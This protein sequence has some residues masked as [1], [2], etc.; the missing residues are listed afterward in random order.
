MRRELVPNIDFYAAMNPDPSDVDDASPI[1]VYLMLRTL[2]NAGAVIES[3]KVKA[4]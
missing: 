4:G 3:K 1:G 2:L